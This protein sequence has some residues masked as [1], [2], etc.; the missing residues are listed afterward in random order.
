MV[1]PHHRDAGF[2]LTTDHASL[3]SD[4]GCAGADPDLAGGTRA[5][6]A[7]DTSP[8]RARRAERPG[9]IIPATS[10]IMAHLLLID[11]DRTSSLEP[12]I[13]AFPAPAHRVEMA[14]TGAEGLERARSRR[15]DVILLDPRLPDQPGLEVY[16]Q[17]RRDRCAHSHHLRDDR[18]G[19]RCGHRS[20]E[21]GCL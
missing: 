4:E 18:Q 13:R 10:E 5:P 17:I 8:P 15:P 2:E 19:G 14:A 20:D 21:A 9:P 11:D 3:C 16:R 6:A 7:H 1:V 12:V